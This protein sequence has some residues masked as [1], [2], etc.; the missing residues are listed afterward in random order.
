MSSNSHHHVVVTFIKKLQL[1]SKLWTHCDSVDKVMSISNMNKI[2]IEKYDRDYL[3]TGIWNIWCVTIYVA[4]NTINNSHDQKWN[5]IPAN[6]DVDYTK[7][8]GRNWGSPTFARSPITLFY[9]EWNPN[10]PKRAQ[11][12]WLQ[13]FDVDFWIFLWFYRFS[14]NII[15]VDHKCHIHV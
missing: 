8:V 6:T 13:G 4:E 10:C 5:E 9:A 2:K 3:N 11:Y 12:K 15:D 1:E 7:A 14:W